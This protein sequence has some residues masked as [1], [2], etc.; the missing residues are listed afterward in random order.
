MRARI[1][2]VNN[3]RGHLALLPSLAVEVMHR[4]QLFLGGRPL[5]DRIGHRTSPSLAEF[6]I[7][8]CTS[9]STNKK[10]PL[11]WLDQRGLSL[12]R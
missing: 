4:F 8:H 9:Q 3:M 10:T 7:A 2:I 11:T 5:R 12:F 6:C 1:L